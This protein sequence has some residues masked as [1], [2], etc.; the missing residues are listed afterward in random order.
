[1]QSSL[2]NT[3]FTIASHLS[4]A[5]GTKPKLRQWVAADGKFKQNLL[6]ASNAPTN[7]L[8]SWATVGLSA[9]PLKDQ[10]ETLDWRAELIGC[11]HSSQEEMLNIIMSAAYEVAKMGWIPMPGTILL[12]AISPHCPNSAMKHLY[13]TLP[14]PWEEDLSEFK[15]GKRR[16]G[17]FYL[18]PISEAEK[19]LAEKAGIEALETLLENDSVDIFDLSRASSL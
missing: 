10:G 12:D 8:T 4:N 19:T 15:V 3:D 2:N 18:C 6:E 5:L 16:L 14:V 1:M 11:A 9:L 7:G 17:W 13:V